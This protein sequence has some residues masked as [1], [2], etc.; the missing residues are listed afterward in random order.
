MCV[1]IPEPGFFSLWG[2][3]L[4][5]L[6]FIATGQVSL[7]RSRHNSPRLVRHVWW[8]SIALS[9]SPHHTWMYEVA[10]EFFLFSLNSGLKHY[11]HY[12]IL[13][14]FLSLKW[15]PYSIWCKLS[16]R[17]S[18]ICCP[19]SAKHSCLVA[20]PQDSPCLSSVLQRISCI[21]S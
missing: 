9:T 1:N 16:V 4:P 11:I 20:T 13:S 14:C 3:A 19:Q 18:E 10:P 17:S 6:R 21:C 7:L 5:D 15:S 12:V 2:W 8:S